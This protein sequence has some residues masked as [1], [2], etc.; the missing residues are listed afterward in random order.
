M[1]KKLIHYY[2]VHQ[3]KH[4][5]RKEKAFSK[6]FE[7]ACCVIGIYVV[8]FSDLIFVLL[9]VCTQRSHEVLKYPNYFK[10]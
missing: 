8:N 4:V 3:K 6:E 10:T 5:T 1:N 7:L 2:Y 9:V